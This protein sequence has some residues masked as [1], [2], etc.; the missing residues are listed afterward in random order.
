[1]D[2]K[3]KQLKDDKNNKVKLLRTLLKRNFELRDKVVEEEENYKINK[4]ENIL[5]NIIITKLQ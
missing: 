1:M 3:L 4:L 5:L 2:P